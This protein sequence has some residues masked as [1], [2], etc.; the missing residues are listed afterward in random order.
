[1]VQT[2]ISALKKQR[3]KGYEFK[4]NLGYTEEFYLERKIKN[5]QGVRMGKQMTTREKPCE[6]AHQNWKKSQSLIAKSSH[7]FIR[8]WLC[9]IKK[10]WG[11][12][13]LISLV[14]ISKGMTTALVYKRVFLLS[15]SNSGSNLRPADQIL[16]VYT[17][18][19]STSQPSIYKYGC[20]VQPDTH[21]WLVLKI[22]LTQPW[23]VW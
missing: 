11:R 12:I 8:H 18:L 14:C 20:S 6:T 10:V 4:T 7:E 13:H 15:L 17:L 5:K 9:S 2:E 3:K 1:M 19:F 23:T 21:W 16:S 22:N